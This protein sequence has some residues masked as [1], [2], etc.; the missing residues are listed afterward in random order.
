M[1]RQ[2][3]LLTALSSLAVRAA[4]APDALHRIAFVATRPDVRLEILDWGGHGPALV[5]LAGFGNTGHVFDGF[6]P[7]FTNRFHV[8]AVTRRGFGASS[9]P[10]TG[11]DTGSL[12]QDIAAVLDSMGIRRASFVG[13]SFAGTELS[14]LGAYH[15][16]RVAA[17][18]YLDASYDFGHLYGDPRWKRAFPIPRPPAPATAGIPA[19]RRWLA[20]VM[21]PEVPDDEIRNLTSNASTAGLDT[22]LQRGAFPTAL[23]HIKAPVLAF[24]AAP[25]SV[26]DWYPYWGSLDSLERSRLQESFNDQEA[27]RRDHLKTFR[28]QVHGARVVRVGGA[29]HYLFLTHPRQVAEQMRAFL[30]SPEPQSNER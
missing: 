30:A 1:R 3:F 22:T 6:A 13:H 20:S 11:Y 25:R 16:G 21:G 24:W 28:E 5:F 18:V 10:P 8:L 17:L 15:P 12:A 2:L 19:L 14:F 27:V 26:K 7:Q 4:L 29:R 23:A 9:R